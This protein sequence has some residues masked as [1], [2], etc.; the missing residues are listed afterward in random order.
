[1]T[2]LSRLNREKG[3]ATALAAQQ[4]TVSN[5]YNPTLDF[6]NFMIPALLIILLIIICG[7]LPALNIVSEKESGTIEAMNVTPVGRL[8]FVLSKLIPYW[9]TAL[10]VVTMGMLIG[11][12]VYGLAPAGS[13]WAIYLATI[14]F[15]FVMSGLGV[16]IANKS[17]TMLQAIFVMFAFIVIFQ[18]MGG[19]FTPIS[20][21][22]GWAQIITYALPPRYFNEIIRAIYLKG[23]DIPDLWQQYLALTILALAICTAAALTYRKRN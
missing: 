13:L 17:A 2:T 12:L 14:L 18:L 23:A 6:R 9:L 20:S 21:M 8:T 15:S 3:M 4:P 19:L 10:L 16:A 5:R 7:F 1:M 22:P 11:W